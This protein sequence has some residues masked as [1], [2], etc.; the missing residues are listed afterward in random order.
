MSFILRH[1]PDAIGLHLDEQ[2]WAS[3]DEL[4]ACAAKHGRELNHER[5]QEV[6]AT[7]NKKR[8]ALSE[9]GTKIRASQGHSIQ[10]DL[11]LE[12]RMPP[13]F[14]FHGTATRFLTAIEQQGLKPKGRQHVH[15]SSDYETAV[16]VGTRHGIPIV[17]QIKAKQM[18]A[19]GAK[20]YLSEN[21]VWLTD[22]VTP[23]YFRAT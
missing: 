3:V 12:D 6:V 5:I 10:V 9:N 18:H 21:N 11:G 13:Q 22:R 4:I 8:F 20:F 7:N 1:K 2:G 15:L 19:D 23:E 17:L 14:L 16:S